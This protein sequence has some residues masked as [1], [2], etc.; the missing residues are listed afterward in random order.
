MLILLICGRQVPID[1]QELVPLKAFSFWLMGARG[2]TSL[3]SPAV[4]NVSF[5]AIERWDPRLWCG[6]LTADGGGDKGAAG[7]GGEGSAAGDSHGGALQEHGGG[8]GRSRRRGW[9]LFDEVEVGEG[10]RNR[11]ICRQIQ[12][13]PALHASVPAA[14]QGACLPH[15]AGLGLPGSRAQHTFQGG[16]HVTVRRALPGNQG[17]WGLVKP[18]DRGASGQSKVAPVVHLSV[19]CPPAAH[20]SELAQPRTTCNLDY[21][22]GFT[23]V[24]Q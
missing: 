12:R 7:G 21:D 10:F 19:A 2:S 3:A 17:G 15:P 24:R 13:A 6:G 11:L 18:R 1:L 4:P 8:I 9:W 20:Y 22:L 23:R 16:R 5:R 14:Y